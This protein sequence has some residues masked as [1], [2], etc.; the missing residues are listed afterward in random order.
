MTSFPP[1]LLPG[2]GAQA[3]LVGFRAVLP[4]ARPG[5]KQVLRNGR[6]D[7]WRPGFAE[8]GNDF[9]PDE[10]EASPSRQSESSKDRLPTN[11]W[12]HLPTCSHPG[13]GTRLL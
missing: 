13:M 2:N 4:R 10:D 1:H 11:V 9:D 6:M 7:E 5:A 3:L 8:H 12:G